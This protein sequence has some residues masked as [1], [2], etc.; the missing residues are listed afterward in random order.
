MYVHNNM[1][2]AL[3][4]NYNAAQ[5]FEKTYVDNEEEHNKLVSETIY[6]EYSVAVQYKLNSGK[7]M[8]FEPTPTDI[9]LSK[10][11]DETNLKFK[12]LNK[13]NIEQSRLAMFFSVFQIVMFLLISQLNLYRLNSKANKPLKQD[14]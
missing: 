7:Y 5:L 3:E 1:N 14:K 11:H 13:F 2:N 9:E 4:P 6:R 12:E 10:T 8:V